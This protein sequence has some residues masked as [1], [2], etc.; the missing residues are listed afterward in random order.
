MARL[1]KTP[2]QPDRFEYTEADHEHIAALRA[3]QWWR[4][5][6]DEHDEPQDDVDEITRRN[7]SFMASEK[8]P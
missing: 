7:R 6:D 8:Y 4:S 5:R 2:G 3:R 1:I